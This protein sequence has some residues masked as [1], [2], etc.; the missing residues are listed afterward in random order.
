MLS[1]EDVHPPL[2]YWLLKISLWVLPGT[3]FGIRVLSVLCSVGTLAVMIIFVRRHWGQRAACYVGLLAALSPFDIYYAQ[4][5]RMYALLAFLFVLSYTQLVGSIEGRPRSLSIW[6]F[7]CIGLAW[8][9]V[10]GVL[11]VFLEVGILLG[12]W[13]WHK[14]RGQSQR[15]RRKTAMAGL[16]R[17]A[18]W[19]SADFDLFLA[20]SVSGRQRFN[21]KR[22]P[23]A[24][25]HSLF[26]RRADGLFSRIWHLV[27]NT[28]P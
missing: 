7:A 10:Y 20:S 3:E 6:M 11:A 25:Y 17:R 8:T 9:H 15:I 13:I 23:L 4:E 2:Y 26:M 22:R 12:F 18:S 5:A 14:L 21:S 19:H 28:R 24:L 1:W 16:W 27:A